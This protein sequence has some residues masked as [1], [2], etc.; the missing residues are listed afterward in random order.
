VLVQSRSLADWDRRKLARELGLL[1]QLVEDPFPATALEAT[2]WVG[3][4]T[5]ISGRGKA[6]RPAAASAAL[7]NVDLAVRASG[8]CDALR[9][10]A[11]SA[12]DRNDPGAGPRGSCST[13]RSSS[14][15]PTPVAV[16]GV[17]PHCADAG[18][19]WSSACTTWASPRGSATCAAAARRRRWQHGSGETVLTEHSL[20]ELYGIRARTAVDG[21]R[22]FVA[23]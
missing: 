15:T 11:P 14:S 5:S 12:V 10:R 18:R 6:A 4:R 22:T 23:S 8:H 2:S 13:N 7:A 16:L 19:T 9:G 20:S 17:F 1:P 21:G 3:T